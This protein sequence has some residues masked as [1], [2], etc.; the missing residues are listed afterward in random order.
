M[1]EE[2]IFGLILS[3]IGITIKSKPLKILFICAGLFMVIENL[4]P[5]IITDKQ[6]SWIKSKMNN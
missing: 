2:I 1:K 3:G 4:L 6:M 5:K